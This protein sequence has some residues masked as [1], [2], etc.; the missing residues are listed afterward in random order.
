MITAWLLWTCILQTGSVMGRTWLITFSILAPL[1]VALVFSAPFCHC[2][3][4]EILCLLLQWKSETLS[5]SFRGW[6]PQWRTLLF[7][8]QWRWRLPSACIKQAAVN[9][10]SSHGHTVTST[11]M[12][13]AQKWN[14][15]LFFS[16]FFNTQLLSH[17]CFVHVPHVKKPM[18]SV[19]W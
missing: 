6:R 4:N 18:C 17:C 12:A 16:F 9:D 10:P 1:S 5:Q 19:I 11:A 13:P 2:K 3:E 7:S 8:W 15:F 14:L